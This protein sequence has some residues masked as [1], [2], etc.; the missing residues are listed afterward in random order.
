MFFVEHRGLAATSIFP[1]LDIDL[2]NTCTIVPHSPVVY[3]LSQI[4]ITHINFHNYFSK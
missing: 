1:T 3:C 4:I 2:N